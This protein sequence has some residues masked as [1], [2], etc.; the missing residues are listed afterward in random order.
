[1]SGYSG[2][3]SFW[4]VGSEGT[5]NTAVTCNK[6]LGI[7]ASVYEDITNNIQ[8]ISNLG[9][10]E[11]ADLVVGTFDATIGLDGTLNSGAI[12]ELFFGQAVDTATSTDYKHVFIN[13]GSGTIE[14]KNTI[15]SFSIQGNYDSTSDYSSKYT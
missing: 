2:H 11:P 14:T 10:R 9:E 12:F 7:L 4:L 15:S 5:F 13:K 8:V 6:D 1:M 3:Q